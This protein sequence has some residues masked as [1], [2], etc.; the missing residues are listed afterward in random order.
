[1]FPHKVFFMLSFLMDLLIIAL[2]VLL[3]KPVLILLLIVAYAI[4]KGLYY[5]HRTNHQINIIT[6]KGKAAI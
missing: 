2:A 6:D 4:A 3:T 5:H 1:M